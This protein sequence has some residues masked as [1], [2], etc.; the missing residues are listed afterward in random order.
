MYEEILKNNIQV[1]NLLIYKYCIPIDESS[2]RYLETQITVSSVQDDGVCIE[3]FELFN[4]LESDTILPY[5]SFKPIVVSTNLLTEI[6]IKDDDETNN[7][8]FNEQWK[9]FKYG[10][11]KLALQFAAVY[12]YTEVFDSEINRNKIVIQGNH[13][14]YIHEVQNLINK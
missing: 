12:K 1:G 13:L 6:G 10:N 3:E 2:K 8:I 14:R 11:L 9:L 4:Y 7:E 5:S